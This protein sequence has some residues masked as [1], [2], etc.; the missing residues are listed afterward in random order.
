MTR[1]RR[2]ALFPA[3]AS[4]GIALASPLA[5]AQ[6]A[7][8]GGPPEAPHGGPHG[9]PMHM[10]IPPVPPGVTLTDE[11][12]AQV[13]AIFDKA[14]EDGHEIHQQMK[15][16]HEQIRT[17]LATEGNLNRAALRKLS[18]QEE[19]LQ[20]KE[21]DSRLETMEKIHD[22]LTPEQRRQGNET[23]E[24]LKSLHEQIRALVGN[25]PPPPYG[26]PDGGP[27]PNAPADAH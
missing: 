10:M 13:Q 20:A 23:M 27:G 22:L 4:L 11:Q 8:Q 9:G 2:I 16:L 25:P 15:A 12:K 14:R 7:P 6:V 24:K 21:A 3:L 5:I 26:G 18:R 17:E 1:F 19:R